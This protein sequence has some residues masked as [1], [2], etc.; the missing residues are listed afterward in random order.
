MH[1]LSNILTELIF[2]LLHFFV[3]MVNYFIAGKNLF[4]PSVLFSFLWAA[5]LLTHL[6]FGLTVL[7]ELFP[8]TLETFFVML[9]GTICFSFGCFIV[10]ASI[11]QKNGSSP[12]VKAT[13]NQAYLKISLPLR[14]LFVGIVVGGLPLYIMAS[15]RVFLASQAENFFVGLRT[16]LSFGEEDIGLTKYLISFSFVVFAISYYTSLKEGG[17]LNKVL[18]VLSLVGTLVY[19]VFATGRLY[20]MII[21]AIYLGISYLHKN[22][23]SLKKFAGLVSFFISLFILIGLIYNK[24]GDV[25]DSLTS[26]VRASSETTAIYLVSSITALDNEMQ[27]KVK[28]SYPGENT[29]RFF[30]KIGQQLN[31]IPNKKVGSILSPFVFIPYPTN[32]YTIYSAYIRDFGKLYAWFMIAFFGAVHTWIYHKAIKTKNLRYTLYYS[33]LLF[34]LL[35]SFFQDQYMSLFSLWL[36]LLFHVEIFLVLNKLFLGRSR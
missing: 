28:A 12:Q 31:M 3:F 23:F 34:P 24:G 17:I 15:Y 22:S 2:I 30:V 16:E 14:I 7:N 8:I 25:E 1:E 33:F 18:L 29:L 27:N 21:L 32:V 5:I 26:N 11:E 36:Q 4:Y 6:I 35:M 19:S 10:T 13:I 9:I 20:Y